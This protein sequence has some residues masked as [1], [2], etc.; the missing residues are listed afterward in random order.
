MVTSTKALLAG[1]CWPMGW[2]A[3]CPL[4]TPCTR[5]SGGE[6]SGRVKGRSTTNTLNNQ[7]MSVSSR[8]RTYNSVEWIIAVSLLLGMLNGVRACSTIQ[9][10]KYFF[11]NFY[12][13]QF[14]WPGR[15]M[16]NGEMRHDKILKGLSSN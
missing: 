15:M 8:G 9:V 10:V 2:A 4:T 1:Q 16:F 5:A 12:N 3:N 13:L 11:Y 6:A 14:L 7:S